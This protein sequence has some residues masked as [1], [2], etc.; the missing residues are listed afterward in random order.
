MFCLAIRHCPQYKNTECCFENATMHSL[1]IVE[2]HVAASN[3][4]VECYHGNT[5]M[6][7][8]HIFVKLQNMSYCQQYM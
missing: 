3:I 1:C 5:T 6:G 7:S 2:Q 4:S 8:H